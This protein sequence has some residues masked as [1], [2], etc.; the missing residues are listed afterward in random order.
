MMDYFHIMEKWNRYSIPVSGF[1]N[2]LSGTLH[3]RRNH[4]SERYICVPLDITHLCLLNTEPETVQDSPNLITI[5][6]KWYQFIH[7]KEGSG[8]TQKC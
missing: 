3:N 1:C 5:P 8:N 4:H 7:V 6:T 2:V